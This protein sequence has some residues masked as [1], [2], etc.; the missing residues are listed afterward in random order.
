MSVSKSTKL[1]DLGRFKWIIVLLISTLVFVS[2][3][4]PIAVLINWG[5]S[6]TINY[7]DF[8]KIQVILNSI[9][10][11]FV[12]TLV[13][14]LLAIPIAFLIAKHK[15]TFSKMIEKIS[16]IGFVL[17]G[18]VVAL[19]V[20]YFGINFAMPIYQTMMLLAIGYI[21]LFIPVAIG[22]I[23][24]VISQMNPKL[25]ESA[26]SLGASNFK[27][28]Q[29]ISYSNIFIFFNKRSFMFGCDFFWV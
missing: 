27:I 17:P 9:Y 1:I 24:P 11:S 16:Y 2:V 13:T 26:K 29:K 10:A 25:E 21:I 3:I 23:K 28:W 14:V 12:G 20:V 5:Y 7:D 18:I 19:A 4:F 22:I 8:F 15:N 6:F